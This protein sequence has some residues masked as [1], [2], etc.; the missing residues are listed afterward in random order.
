M[1][2]VKPGVLDTCSQNRTKQTAKYNS[3][4]SRAVILPIKSLHFVRGKTGCFGFSLLR[5]CE[6]TRSG[7][8]WSHS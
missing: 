2:T 6:P 4:R 7:L 5:S 1:R 3:R 8:V